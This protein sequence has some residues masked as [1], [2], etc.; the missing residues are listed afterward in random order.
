MPTNTPSETV[1]RDLLKG[2]YRELDVHESA[3]KTTTHPGVKPTNDTLIAEV[4]VA[5]AWVKYLLQ[6]PLEDVEEYR[7]FLPRT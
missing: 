4:R 3:N 6:E 5:I 7:K 1:L 2:L